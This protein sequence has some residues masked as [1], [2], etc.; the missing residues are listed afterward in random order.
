MLIVATR[1]SHCSDAVFEFVYP[2]FKDFYGTI[3]ND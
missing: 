1:D 2:S 3:V